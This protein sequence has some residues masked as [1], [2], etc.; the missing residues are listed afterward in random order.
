[1]CGLDWQH[2]VP[3]T[4]APCPAM[5]SERPLNALE[6]IFA[7]CNVRF[8]VLLILEAEEVVETVLAACDACQL[9]HLTL[10]H[11]D[12]WMLLTEEVA[13]VV[14]GREEGVHVD[15]FGVFLDDLISRESLSAEGPMTLRLIPYRREQGGCQ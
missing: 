3:L 5:R 2:H 4:K 9:G 8:A 6:N 7:S 14:P 13:T 11:Q 15:D 10:A 1:M 12:G